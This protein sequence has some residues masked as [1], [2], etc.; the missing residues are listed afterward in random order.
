M[1]ACSLLAVGVDSCDCVGDGEAELN[2]EG[3]SSRYCSGA[4]HSA[5]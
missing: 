1:G 2:R 3:K 5:R 4:Y